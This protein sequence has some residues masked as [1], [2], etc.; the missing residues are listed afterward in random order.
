M[1]GEGW[2]HPYQVMEALEGYKRAATAHG[3]Q[4]SC[5][6]SGDVSQP[7]TSVCSSLLALIV[8]LGREVVG[9]FLEYQLVVGSR[10]LIC[11]ACMYCY[12]S[13]SIII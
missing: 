1:K 12:Q 11:E 5:L 6:V 13:N 3:W 4:V 8:S 9:I 10:H 7:Y 2:K